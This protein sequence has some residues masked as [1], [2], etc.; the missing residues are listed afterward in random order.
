M[1]WSKAV[2]AGCCCCDAH[3]VAESGHERRFANV[4]DGGSYR[5]H[6]TREWRVA[7]AASVLHAKD[8]V[9]DALHFAEPR[10]VQVEGNFDVLV[11]RPVDLEGEPGR[12]E[13]NE[14]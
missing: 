12:R 8:N 3:P 14:P 11:V 9:H 2:K 5:R 4:R 13:L 1:V 7:T 10:R 6:R